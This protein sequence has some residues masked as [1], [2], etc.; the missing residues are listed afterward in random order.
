[1]L[2][3]Y[4]PPTRRDFWKVTAVSL[5]LSRVS[6]C[7][8]S[9]SGIESHPYRFVRYLVL[10]GGRGKSSFYSSTFWNVSVHLSQA[11]LKPW[12]NLLLKQIQPIRHENLIKVQLSNIRKV[13]MFMSCFDLC[14][15]NWVIYIHSFIFCLC[16]FGFR[17]WLFRICFSFSTCI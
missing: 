8:S 14:S 16:L 9:P 1:M 15:A 7:I 4:C 5:S 12:H 6:P 3:L 10:I 13:L 2:P 17:K 11:F